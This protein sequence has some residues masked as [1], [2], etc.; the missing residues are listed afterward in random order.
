MSLI[1][2]LLD[3]KAQGHIQMETPSSH[4]PSWFPKPGLFLAVSSPSPSTL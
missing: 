3:P 4:L 2:E 1:P